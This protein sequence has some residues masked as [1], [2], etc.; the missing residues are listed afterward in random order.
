MVDSH[1]TCAIGPWLTPFL[2]YGCCRC[3][4]IPRTSLRMPNNNKQDECGCCCLFPMEFP[5]FSGANMKI[6][7]PRQHTLWWK[8]TFTRTSRLWNDR[9]APQPG[10]NQRVAGAAGSRSS[11]RRIKSRHIIELMAVLFPANHADIGEDA[12]M[13]RS[14]RIRGIIPNVAFIFALK[15]Q[16]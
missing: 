7:V 15:W 6:P 13:V 1:I 4:F 16:F 9:V 12:T 14:V 5:A 8:R 3:C 11:Q 2:R 10:N